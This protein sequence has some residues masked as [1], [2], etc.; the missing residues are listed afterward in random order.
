MQRTQSMVAILSSPAISVPRAD[1][2]AAH[3]VCTIDFVNLP[4]LTSSSLGLSAPRGRA[5]CCW[6]VFVFHPAQDRRHGGPGRFVGGA[7]RLCGPCTSVPLSPAITS[8]ATDP[9][10]KSALHPVPGRP[11]S[12]FQIRPL[13]AWSSIVSHWASASQPLSNQRTDPVIQ[14]VFT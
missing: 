14:S 10:G 3:N 1:F 6:P 8:A 4:I 11:A 5:P 2:R 12:D 9:S 7:C 13:P